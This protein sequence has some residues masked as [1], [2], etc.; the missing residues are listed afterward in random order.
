MELNKQSQSAGDNSTQMQATTINNYYSTVSGIDET[1]ARAI[2]KE[3]YAIARQ[4]WS[5]EAFDIADQRVH[6][7]EDRLMPMMLAY[8]NS[9]SFFGDPAF[10][11]T[12]RQAQISA[13]TSDRES[14]YE[15]LS[16]L[17]LHR[18]EQGNNLDRRLGVCKAIEIVNQVTEE[19]LVGL[20]MVY[21]VSK[22][23]PVSHE[24][25]EGLS[26]L[27]A[28]Y[29]RIMDG[30]KLPIDNGWMENLDLLS[31]IRLG[32]QGINTFKKIEEFIPLRLKNYLVSGIDSNSEEFI[33]LR[34]EFKKVGFPDNCFIQHGLK[35]NFVKLSV[36]DDV[37]RI[38]INLTRKDGSILAV[39]LN[40]EQK[41]AMK[42]AIGLLGKDESS[43]VDLKKK[44]IEKW[45]K[46][47][48]LRIV[49]DWWNNL[50][51]HFSITPAGVAL[52][53]AY[54]QSK[55]PNIPGL[56]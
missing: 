24:V 36:N 1:R 28:L 37:D 47:T 21:V 16:K 13:A 19:A 35:P 4:N 45:N 33:E 52:A 54:A 12:L 50:P 31:A 17:L 56:Y 42:R 2:C 53:N 44:L 15:M 3:E 18:I 26:V 55:D 6:R 38:H 39:P 43:N 29:G 32:V 7:L 40:E 11:L 51:V 23:I 22:F 27:D 41:K 5:Q 14:D 49:K 10:Q 20:T 48:N 34:N 25:N 8:D 9:L 30:N 46:Y